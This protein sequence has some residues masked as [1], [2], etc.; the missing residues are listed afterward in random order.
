MEPRRV[1]AGQHPP[2]QELGWTTL[3]DAEEFALKM[4]Y[5]FALA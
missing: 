1:H 5:D 4:G 3:T 2:E